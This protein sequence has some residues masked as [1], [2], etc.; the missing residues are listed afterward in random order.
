MGI[1]LSQYTFT[2]I[3]ECYFRLHYRGENVFISSKYCSVQFLSFFCSKGSY[4]VSAACKVFVAKIFTQR[5]C[6]VVPKSVLLEILPSLNPF[7]L[8]RAIFTAPEYINAALFKSPWSLVLSFY[9]MVRVNISPPVNLA[10][11][12]LTSTQ[13]D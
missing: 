10:P 1:I 8:N 3:L 4:F 13:P 11:L 6:T 9:C 2:N 5:L 12:V 7:A